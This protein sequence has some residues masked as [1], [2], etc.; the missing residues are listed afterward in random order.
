MSLIIYFLKIN[1]KYLFFNNN[2][3]NKSNYIYFINS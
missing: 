2:K 3:N 1:K